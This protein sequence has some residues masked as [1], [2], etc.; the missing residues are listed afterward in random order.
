MNIFLVYAQHPVAF[1]FKVFDD[2]QP[3]AAVVPIF[4]PAAGLGDAMQKRMVLLFY[5][6]VFGQKLDAKLRRFFLR[7]APGSA[8]AFGAAE[9]QMRK[10]DG[11][12]SL[13][14]SQGKKIAAYS[15]WRTALQASS[16][17]LRKVYLRIRL[18]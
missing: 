10:S 9:S 2:A 5:V 15:S 8:A 12:C 3:A 17:G 1:G 16:S 18:V 14:S 13:L 11:W 4:G 7:P 6:F